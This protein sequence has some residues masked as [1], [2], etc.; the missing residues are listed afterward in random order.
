M[1]NVLA[2]WYS[3]D[4]L[5]GSDE[6]IDYWVSTVKG[7]F[8][9]ATVNIEFKE[10]ETLESLTD[11]GVMMVEKYYNTYA[12]HDR[13]NYEVLA[14][15]SPFWIPLFNLKGRA[16]KKYMLTGIID[17]LVK[18]RDDKIIVMD[19]KTLGRKM[20]ENTPKTAYQITEY[21]LGAIGLGHVVNH[22]VF[23]NLY[24]TKEPKFD[25]LS[26][27]REDS[28]LEDFM[29]NVNDISKA[30][31]YDLKHKNF[32]QACYMCDLR[33]YC[34]HGNKDSVLFIQP[35]TLKQRIEE[36]NNG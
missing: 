18:D 1:H 21:Y 27:T 3:S 9:N 11:Y 20:D 36:E 30:I 16:S 23:N 13:E 8:N 22:G 19:H 14:V 2:F 4:M 31:S 12:E 7:A 17:L 35:K 34:I 25:R 5:P 26:A 6:L 28:Q 15:E 10:D 33:D 32:G 29:N 24:K